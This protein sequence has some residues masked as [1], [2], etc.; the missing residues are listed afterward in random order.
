M[1]RYLDTTRKGPMFLRLDSVAQL[2]KNSFETG[3]RLGH[4]RLHA[5]VVMANHVHILI[6]PEVDPTRSIAS[7]KGRPPVLPTSCSGAPVSRFGRPSVRPLGP[8]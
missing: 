2:V 6:T 7:L 3:E 8:E 1:D 4:Y 5:W